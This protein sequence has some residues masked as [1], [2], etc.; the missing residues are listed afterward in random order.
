M[1][2]A[3]P[4]RIPVVVAFTSAQENVA[5]ATDYSLPLAPPVAQDVPI[6]A[7]S[8]TRETRAGGLSTRSSILAGVIRT[9]DDGAQLLVSSLDSVQLVIQQ[10]TIRGLFVN[11][12]SVVLQI[13]ATVNE[14]W[15]V[16]GD[17]KTNRM[18]TLLGKLA[19]ER[20]SALLLVS[21]FSLWGF[22]WSIRALFVSK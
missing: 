22:L 15:T 16:A 21:L 5:C 17:T 10:G 14:F 12:C 13:D 9:L 4:S 8:F 1:P 2:R 20:N 6:G 11:E 7:V 19:F 3:A 18:P